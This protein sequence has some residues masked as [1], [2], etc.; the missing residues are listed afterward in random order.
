MKTGGDLWGT[1][2]PSLEG[3]GP[4][5]T[6][7]TPRR[8]RVSGIGADSGPSRRAVLALLLAT[9]MQ[10]FDATIVNVALPSIQR[11]LA[12]DTAAAGWVVT[13]YLVAASATMPV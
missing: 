10:A 9:L 6:A 3:R 12:I 5:A 2:Q 13:T 4:P 11:T 7:E 8:G 1:T